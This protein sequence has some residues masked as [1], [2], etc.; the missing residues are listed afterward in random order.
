MTSSFTTAATPS[1]CWPPA[2]EGV[3]ACAL[4]AVAVPGVAAPLFP[5]AAPDGGAAPAAAASNFGA[6]RRNWVC[7]ALV[8]P[9]CRAGRAAAQQ[10]S[11]GRHTCARVGAVAMLVDA[12]RAG[13]VAPATLRVPTMT[14]SQPAAT[15]P[16]AP[17]LPGPVAGYR[18]RRA[19]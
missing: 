3:R 15:V 8:R 13:E 12:K 19:V 4:F 18:G 17:G 7:P 5:A 10:P 16:S 6:G 14:E 1:T 2:A 9:M 11:P